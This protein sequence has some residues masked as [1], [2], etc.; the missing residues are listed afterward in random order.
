MLPIF[1]EL[2]KLADENEARW[3][4]IDVLIEKLSKHTNDEVKEL[5][6]LV[7]LLAEQLRPISSSKAQMEQIEDGMKDIGKIIGV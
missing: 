4:K 7:L 3:E 2:K 6:Q 5:T 1:D